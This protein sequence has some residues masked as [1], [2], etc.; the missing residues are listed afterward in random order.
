MSKHSF[1][2]PSGAAAWSKCALWPT[3]NAK[4]PES[5]T[6]ED[7]SGTQFISAASA[8]GTA[9]HWVMAEMLAGRTPEEDSLTPNGQT[10]TQEM[11]EGAAM[12]RDV[13]I[14]TVGTEP[15]HIEETVKV[16]TIHPD[17]FGTPDIWVYQD[18]AR[19]LDII[20]YKFGHGFV[21]EY[22][23]PQGLLYMA[24]IIATLPTI[25]TQVSFTIVQPRCFHRGEPVRTHTYYINHAGPY[26][27][28]L[29]EA[30]ERTMLPTP[31]ATTGP[32]CDHCPGRHACP[33]LQLATGRDTETSTDQQ[34]VDLTPQAAANELKVLDRA[35]S[36][37]T[38]RVEGLR[39][40]TTANL[41]AGAHVPHYK[42]EAARGSLKWSVAP[43]EVIKLGKKLK[44]PLSL[45]KII[46]PTQAK[47][48]LLDDSIIASYA[49]VIPGGLRLVESSNSEA[50]KVFKK[51]T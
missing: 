46:T 50:A 29:R 48:L 33:T 34:P 21:D 25:P 4:Y 19:Q 5:D 23:N 9:A 43:E 20:D 45:P 35:L 10:V 18:D 37:M 49:S 41:K 13:V 12:V 40:L 51:E 27:R 6:L 17:C 11:L 39:A 16:L 44:V 38:A 1:L 24:G 47:K 42:L 8:E 32:Q 14:A 15:L 3:M 7:E 30:A 2:P 26:L 22:W 36:R 31:T 28:A